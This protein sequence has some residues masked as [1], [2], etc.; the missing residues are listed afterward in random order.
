MAELNFCFLS[1]VVLQGGIGITFLS[2]HF[3]LG[4]GYPLNAQYGEGENL[5]CVLGRYQ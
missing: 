3:F 5:L 4:S 1:T 2:E